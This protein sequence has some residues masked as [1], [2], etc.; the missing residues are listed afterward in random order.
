MANPNLMPRKRNTPKMT[1][2]ILDYVTDKAMLKAWAHLSLSERVL[3]IHEKFNVKMTQQTLGLWYRKNKIRW[4][5]PQYKMLGALKRGSLLQDQAEWCWQLTTYM[6]RGF[7]IIYIDETSSHLWDHKGKVWQP[8][9]DSVHIYRAATR[10]HSVTIIAGL[11]SDGGKLHWQLAKS[12]NKEDFLNFLKKQVHPFVKYPRS[13]VLVLDNHRA[14][15]S[16]VVTE[17]LKEKHYI[18]HFLPP[19]SSEL[20]PI[21]TVWA[22]LKRRWG[23][24][25]SSQA[26]E[27]KMLKIST[28]ARQKKDEFNYDSDGELILSTKQKMS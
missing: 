22:L 4:R 9:D 25:L 5:K 16:L 12:T 2:E 8:N 17:W 7:E 3:K 15:H 26:F 24:M 21:E 19:Y 6:Q 23:K 18:V 14:H 1:P 11:S 10:G 28:Q 20:N 13:T 27:E